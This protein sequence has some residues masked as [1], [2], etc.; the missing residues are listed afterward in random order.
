MRLVWLPSAAD[1]LEEIYEYL[2]ENLSDYI[3]RT[4][5]EIYGAAQS[6]KHTPFRGRRGREQGV[7]ELVLPR[8]PYTIFYRVEN[9]TIEVLYIRHGARDS[10]QL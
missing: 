6:L 10:S 5:N 2:Q 9:Q 3:P 8:L 4:M 7:R 1:D